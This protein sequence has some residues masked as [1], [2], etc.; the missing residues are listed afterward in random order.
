MLHCCMNFPLTIQ[1]W[2]GSQAMFQPLISKVAKFSLDYTPE[3]LQAALTF[4]H[5]MFKSL[6]N[7]LTLSEQVQMS[8]LPEATQ[9]NVC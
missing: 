2:P 5:V 1:S 7:H 3:S 4:I 8:W 6:N 9:N